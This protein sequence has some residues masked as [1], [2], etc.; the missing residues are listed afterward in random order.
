[1]IKKVIDLKYEIDIFIIIIKI[2]WSKLC[3]VVGFCFWYVVFLFMV[4][5]MLYYE[6]DSG[7]C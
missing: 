6:M 1:M 4:C 5:L 2:K 7:G 3:G